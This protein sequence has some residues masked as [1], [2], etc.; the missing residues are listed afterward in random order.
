MARQGRQCR[1]AGEKLGWNEGEFEMLRSKI[2]KTIYDNETDPLR[3]MKTNLDFS[4]EIDISYTDAIEIGM[5]L[6]DPQT[7]IRR[8]VSQLASKSEMKK[9]W[10]GNNDGLFQM[11]AP[12]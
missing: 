2:Q 3:Q 10:G 11:R 4:R 9:A 1:S 5:P 6:V 7:A 12:L 8:Y